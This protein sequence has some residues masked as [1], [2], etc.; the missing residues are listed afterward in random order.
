MRTVRIERRQKALVH[1]HS[2]KISKLLL[3]LAISQVL[4]SDLSAA[5]SLYLKSTKPE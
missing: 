1:K 3:H 4:N 2:D 5:S